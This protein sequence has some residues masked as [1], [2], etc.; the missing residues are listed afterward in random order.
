MFLYCQQ[1]NRNNVRLL[2]AALINDFTMLTFQRPLLNKDLRA[3]RQI[4]TNQSQSVIWAVGP[5]NSQGDTAYHRIRQQGNLI[6]KYFL[7]NKFDW[8]RLWR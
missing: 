8:L 1:G 6:Y 7:I 4:L 5:V 3:D 2:N